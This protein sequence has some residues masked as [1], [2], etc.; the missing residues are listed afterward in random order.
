MNLLQHVFGHNEADLKKAEKEVEATKFQRAVTK[1]FL[2]VQRLE[3]A[4][5]SGVRKTKR[6]LGLQPSKGRS[7]SSSCPTRN[8]KL[9]TPYANAY[10]A[11][12]AVNM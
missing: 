1:Y 5:E 11:S 8:S 10:Q 12:R 9:Y 7:S 6:V 2:P 3:D 4:A